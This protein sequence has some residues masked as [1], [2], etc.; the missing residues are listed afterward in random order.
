M[1]SHV[2][3]GESKLPEA[4]I[5]TGWQAFS[6]TTHKQ[7]R[8]PPQ[9]PF[10]VHWPS[11]PYQTSCALVKRRLPLEAGEPLARH[12]GGGNPFHQFLWPLTA[13]G[14]SCG[15]MVLPYQHIPGCQGE[16]RRSPG[17]LSPSSWSPDPLGV[18]PG[19]GN[20]GS[21]RMLRRQ[22]RWAKRWFPHSPGEGSRGRAALRLKRWE[23]RL[24]CLIMLAEATLRQTPTDHQCPQ[25]LPGKNSG[26]SLDLCD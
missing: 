24:V 13:H 6:I 25:G 11:L 19:L 23:G 17:G 5:V 9:F 12:S 7:V 16:R 8:W 10:L 3:Q 4:Q 14:F 20:A 22:G 26:S 15:R 18:F 1:F 2:P 21:S